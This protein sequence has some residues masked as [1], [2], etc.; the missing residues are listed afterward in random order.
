ML[1]YRCQQELTLTTKS[2]GGDDL[3]NNL[4]EI[5]EAQNMSIMELSRRTGKSRTCIYK[6]ESGIA[7]DVRPST[8]R[9]I[10]EALGRPVSDIFLI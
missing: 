3:I 5:R 8:M 9:A 7:I 4:K 2:K 1:Y 10:A 6:I